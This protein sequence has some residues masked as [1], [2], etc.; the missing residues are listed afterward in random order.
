VADSYGVSGIPNGPAIRWSPSLKTLTITSSN[1]N[2]QLSL[3]YDAANYTTFRAGSTGDLFIQGGATSQGIVLSLSGNATM[4][5]QSIGS[6]AAVNAALK[7][8]TNSTFRYKWTVNDTSNQFVM[9]NSADVAIITTDQNKN[10]VIGSAAL[11]TNATDGF[12]HEQA[13]A[14]T[15]TG[16]PTLFT[17][18]IPHV[19]DSTNKFPYVY[20]GGAWLPGA[21]YNALWTTLLNLASNQFILTSAASLAFGS[22][23][24]ATPDVLLGR[25]GPGILSLENATTAQTLRIYGNTT[26]AKY[27]ALSHDG[28]NG[29][30]IPAVGHLA[31]MSAAH[32]TGATDN[33]F[34]I[35]SSAGAPTGVPAS[36]PTGQIPMQY[37]STNN[38]LYV[39][40]GGWKKSTVYA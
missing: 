30:L 17:G 23:G 22:S 37:D 19:D 9:T 5:I 25:R 1:G 16:V 33:Y 6:G 24:L 4:T 35:P 40:N 27:V 10:V 39:Y 7:F 2:P 20:I 36:I 11:A 26:G 28:T 12:L 3:N 34:T 15:P 21:P 14:G 8:W 32:A 13:C 38:F 31:H 18:R 29:F